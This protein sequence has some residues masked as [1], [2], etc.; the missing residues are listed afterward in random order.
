MTDISTPLNISNRTQLSVPQD[1]KGQPL[2]INQLKGTPP[3]EECSD[4]NVHRCKN[5]YQSPIKLSSSNAINIEQCIHIHGS[6]GC[7]KFD[8]VSKI[9]I[10]NDYVC[11]KINRQLYKLMEYH[12]HTP[13]EHTVNNHKYLAEIHYVFMEVDPGCEENNTDEHHYGDLCGCAHNY[14]NN[15]LVIGRM[16]NDSDEYNELNNVQV[17]I[18]SCYYE[19]DGT[20]TTG[21]FSPVKWIIGKNP[22]HFNVTQLLAVSK[23]SRPLQ[24]LDGRLI[25]YSD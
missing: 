13:G 12:F 10:V 17:K 1:V 25:L 20:L 8:A 6:N 16:I 11:L 15:I 19:Y 14:P 23:S 21:D 4:S 3:L 2:P 18:P 5:Y 9:F 22:I 7:A 24:E